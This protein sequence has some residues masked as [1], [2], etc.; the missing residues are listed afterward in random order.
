MREV[1]L[2][3]LGT[4]TSQL[5]IVLM[6]MKSFAKLENLHLYMEKRKKKKS[7][8]LSVPY[9]KNSVSEEEATNAHDVM[10]GDFSILCNFCRLRSLFV[11]MGLVIRTRGKQ[12]CSSC[13]NGSATLHPNP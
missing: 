10:R 1:I 7:C 2:Q 13:T 3:S 6:P 9:S 5:P 8:K 4:Q 12:T 11:T